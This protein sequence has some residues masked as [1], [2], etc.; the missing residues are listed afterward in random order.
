M[1]LKARGNSHDYNTDQGSS[2]TCRFINR[3]HFLDKK[4]HLHYSGGHRSEFQVLVCLLFIGR[5]FLPKADDQSFTF[6]LQKH[7][8]SREFCCLFTESWHG[9]YPIKN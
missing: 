4:L 1:F 2:K 3:H 6:S 8:K 5:H 7:K 9:G